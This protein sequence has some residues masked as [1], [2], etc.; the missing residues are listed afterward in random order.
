[1]SRFRY[2]RPPSS[3]ITPEAV[4]RRRRELIGLGLASPL[5]AL[6]G[7]AGAEDA[8]AAGTTA[9]P[10]A[11]TDTPDGFRSNEE[12]TTWRDATNYNN[13]YEFGTGKADPARNAHTLV[14][15]PWVVVVGGEAE[16]TGTFPLEDFLRPHAVQERIYRLR[17]VEGWSMVLPWQGV[18]LGEVLARFRPTSK[19][20]YVAFTTLADRGQM[21]G[22]RW[23]VLDWPY[24][25][26]LRIDEAMHPL[27]L[28]ATGL[29]GKPLPN[30]NGAPLR[31]VVPWKYGFKSIK[32]IVRIDFTENMPVTS[33]NQSQP[34]E[35]G[36][37]SN[38]N[39][40]VDH[41]RW[42]QASERRIAGDGRRLVANRIPTLPFNGY[43]AQVA[44]LY[45]GMDLRK[46]F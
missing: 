20:K 7:C 1:M 30:Q 6:A 2:P 21:P 27:T 38:V 16:V 41:P 9:A 39:P 14:T 32:S 8:P 29:Y 13:F 31:L 5:L 3:E 33:W 45:E 28:L 12:L 19:A 23:P 35:Y 10:A 34:S 4:Y 42:S 11:P 46:W 15:N 36:F 17:C 44:S 22:L 18:P 24:R 37:Y 40:A 26:G 25:E 43:G